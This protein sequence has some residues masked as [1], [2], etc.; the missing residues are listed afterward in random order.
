MTSGNPLLVEGAN[1]CR[2]TFIL[3]DNPKY[4]FV[5]RCLFQLKGAF[6]VWKL[7]IILKYKFE[8]RGN[9]MIR[10]SDL[11]KDLHNEK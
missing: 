4:P 6:F 2:M 8:K 3:K 1:S 10:D 11:S 9:H 7:S 5:F